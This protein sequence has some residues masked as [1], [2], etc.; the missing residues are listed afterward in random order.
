MNEKSLA[1]KSLNDERT[2]LYD[3]ATNAGARERIKK[4]AVGTMDSSEILVFGD[5]SKIVFDALS[6]SVSASAA[7][8]VGKKDYEISIK[9]KF[10]QENPQEKLDNGLFS[11]I[12]SMFSIG[13]SEEGTAKKTF[14]K[15][16]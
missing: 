8:A 12:A 5:A 14:H 15:N 4:I 1:Q 11:R 10:E 7:G 6:G 2:S 16:I 13:K 9:N 3:D